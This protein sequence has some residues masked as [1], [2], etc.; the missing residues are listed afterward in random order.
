MKRFF[1]VLYVGL[2]DLLT[3]DRIKPQMISNRTKSIAS[4]IGWDKLYEK[5]K[6]AQKKGNSTI[7]LK[8]YE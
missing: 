1:K 4:K 2:V 3:F 7:N 6:E 8:D 5:A